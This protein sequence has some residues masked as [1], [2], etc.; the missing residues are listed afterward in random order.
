[1]SGAIDDADGALQQAIDAARTVPRDE[2]PDDVADDVQTAIV[3]LLAA[4]GRCEVKT[5]E[6]SR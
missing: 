6:V 5:A 4:K 1:M 3:A 2:L